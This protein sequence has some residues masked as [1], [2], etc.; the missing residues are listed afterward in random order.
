MSIAFSLAIALGVVG[1]SIQG[2]LFAILFPTVFLALM[3]PTMKFA[4][5]LEVKYSVRLEE[6]SKLAAFLGLHAGRIGALCLFG[7]LILA[8]LWTSPAR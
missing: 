2:W 6:G 3:L 1:Y 7:L 4:I 8:M 5:A